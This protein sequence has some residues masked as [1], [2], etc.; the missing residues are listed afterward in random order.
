M[1]SL[2]T[3]MWRRRAIGHKTGRKSLVQ[4]SILAI[5]VARS[6]SSRALQWAHWRRMPV[7][8]QRAC[9]LAAAQGH[10]TEGAQIA[11]AIAKAQ[12]TT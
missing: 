12:E 2:T 10:I 1:E 5:E 3:C 4:S 11:Q 7:T 6:V 8:R 9:S